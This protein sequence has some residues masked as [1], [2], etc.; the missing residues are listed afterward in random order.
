MSTKIK[1][2]L[3]FRDIPGYV[4]G[5]IY[6]AYNVIEK[7]YYVGQ[8]RTYRRKKDKFIPFGSIGRW[9]EHLQEAR[10]P[11]LQNQSSI[12]ISLLILYSIRV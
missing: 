10:N 9:N 5:I 7:K 6:T 12:K 11:D 8:T 4:R 3:K 1:L 2:N